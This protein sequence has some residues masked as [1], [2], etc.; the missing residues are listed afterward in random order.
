MMRKLVLLLSVLV[1]V[2]PASADIF[3]DNFNVG[4]NGPD[5]L[6]TDTESRLPV[7]WDRYAVPGSFFLKLSTRAFGGDN[8]MVLCQWKP[9]PAGITTYASSDV[10]GVSTLAI[11]LETKSEGWGW[12]LTGLVKGIF[13]DADGVALG[14]VTVPLT[15]IAHGVYITETVWTARNVNMAVP[16]GAASA[17]F[18]LEN[19]YSV[20]GGENGSFWVDNFVVTPEPMTIGLL[21]LGALLIRRR[22]A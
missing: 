15:D 16:A 13:K 21:G 4:W 1:F 7:N 2:V 22:K 9:G 10:T 18:V 17:K 6:G 14:T 12:N 5:S 19:Y 11:G 20:A 3:S 8:A